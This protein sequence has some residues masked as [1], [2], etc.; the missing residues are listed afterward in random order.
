[1]LRLILLALLAAP[2]LAA[3]EHYEIEPSHTYPYFEVGHFGFSHLLG[4]FNSTR[5][6]ITLDREAQT[7][8]IDVE[9]DA[10]SID[11][12]FAARDKA[13]RGADFFQVG[14]YPTLRFHASK[15]R[16]DGKQPVAADGDFSMTGVTRPLT[17]TIER[18]ICKPHPYWG[19]PA[20]GA[21]V[22]AVIRR[23]DFG[24]KYGIPFVSDEIRIR[25]EL[26]ALGAEP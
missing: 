9:I 17:L 3:P 2:A 19:K 4:R 7:G 15:L 14:Q 25:I 21:R 24:M 23:S 12:G 6:S 18:L 10:A 20:C 16:F 1:M 11:T 8:S 5:G 22:S 13:L 26:E